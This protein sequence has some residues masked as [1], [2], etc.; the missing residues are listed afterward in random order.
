MLL[1]LM[2]ILGLVYYWTWFLW[3]FTLVISF[4]ALMKSEENSPGLLI[5]AGASLLMILAGLSYP[6]I[7]FA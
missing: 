3:P 2:E 4:A 5:L 1:G 6:D 7:V